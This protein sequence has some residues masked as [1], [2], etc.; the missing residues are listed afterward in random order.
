MSTEADGVLPEDETVE[1]QKITDDPSTEWVS[2]K[3][4][5][6]ELRQL[7]QQEG[8]EVAEED[9]PAHEKA[10]STGHKGHCSSSL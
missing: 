5:E 7:D 3:E 10:H 2:W 4:A 6:N 9:S 1:L 8:F